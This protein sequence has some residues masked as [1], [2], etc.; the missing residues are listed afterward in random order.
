MP[1]N[2]IPLWTRSIAIAAGAPEVMARRLRLMHPA[3]AW[4]PAGVFEVQSMWMEKL[5][6]VCES[7]C[8]VGRATLAT[9]R[10]PH[11]DTELWWLPVQQQRLAYEAVQAAH[12]VLLP[13]SERVSANVLRL[14]R[15]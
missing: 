2:W 4:S 9:V 10:L 12:Q 15:G 1:L 5:A 7:W 13:V 3:S 8:A 6:A 14:R 11:S